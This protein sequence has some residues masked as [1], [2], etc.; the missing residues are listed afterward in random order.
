MA[1]ASLPR[2]QTSAFVEAIFLVF[3]F[4][5]RGVRD[6]EIFLS[7]VHFIRDLCS[8]ALLNKSVNNSFC[9]WVGSLIGTMWKLLNDLVAFLAH[10]FLS[11]FFF[12]FFFFFLHE[13]GVHVSVRTHHERI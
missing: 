1:F 5:N 10:I 9:G 2:A 11:L 13:R 7:F 12:F 3:A 6:L 8:N 4:F